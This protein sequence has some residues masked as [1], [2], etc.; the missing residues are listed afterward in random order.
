MGSLDA[1]ARLLSYMKCPEDELSVS[2][3][4]LT[5]GYQES[6]KNNVVPFICLVWPSF[7]SWIKVVNDPK[8]KDNV[9]FNQDQILPT[10]TSIKLPPEP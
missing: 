4:M 10:F 5:V 9:Q 8:L 2:F 1:F 3:P 6:I 7:S